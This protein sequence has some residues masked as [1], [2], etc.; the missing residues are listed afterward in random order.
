MS[1][2]LRSMLKIPKD[3]RE[4]IFQHKTKCPCCLSSSAFRNN[5]GEIICYTCGV[6]NIADI[7]KF[8]SGELSCIQNT[9]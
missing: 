3:I 7:Q 8:K 6:F 5:K 2:R 9:L 1:L 4:N